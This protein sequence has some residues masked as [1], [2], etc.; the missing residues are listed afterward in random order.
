M[1]ISADTLEKFTRTAKVFYEEQ[2]NILQG[3]KLGIDQFLFGVDDLDTS[4]NFTLDNL[5]VNPHGVSFRNRDEQSHVRPFENGSGKVYEVP[6]VSEKTPI[7]E[8]LMDAVVAG[9]EATGGLDVATQSKVAKIVNQ[10][11]AAHTATRWKLALDTIRTGVFSPTGLQGRDIGLQIDYGRDASLSI[12]YD[13]TAV[14]ANVDEA[15][16][17]LYDAYRN[18]GGNQEAICIVAGSDWL[19]EFQKDE[20]VLT[21]MQANA[22]NILVRQALMPPELRNVQGLYLIAEYLIPGTLT[23]VFICGY[24]PRYEFIQYAGASATAFMPSDEAIIFSIGDPRYRVFRG[25]D[26]L[27][28][29]GNK[30]RTVGEI[31]FD[32]FVTQDPVNEWLRS[33]SRFAFVPGNVNRTGKSK[34]TFTAAS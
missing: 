17:E 14:G 13:F 33:Q 6:H 21:R 26:A 20:D 3:G 29:S 34:G 2:G 12:T 32:G 24:Q 31:V 19:T 22:A 16:F 4:A 27:D 28:G 15:L 7:S 11:V 25:V 18:Q 5:I 10:H 8:T 9:I 1:G 30:V 23:P